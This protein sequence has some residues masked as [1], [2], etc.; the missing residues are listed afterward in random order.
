M[1]RE[2]Q[3]GARAALA[4][5]VACRGGQGCAQPGACAGLVAHCWSPEGR[6]EGVP[7]LPGRQDKLL[8]PEPG[9]EGQGTRQ[10]RG[11]GPGGLKRGTGKLNHR[12]EGHG[13]PSYPTQGVPEGLRAGWGWVLRKPLAGVA[14]RQEGWEGRVSGQDRPLQ[15]PQRE[16]LLW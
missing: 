14:W 3:G 6:W 16:G 9:L 8:Q 10:D 12:G 7:T 2:G 5:G 4:A 15:L 11:C 13:G 1:D